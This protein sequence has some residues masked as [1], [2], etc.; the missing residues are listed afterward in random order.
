MDDSREPTT[1]RRMGLS[2]LAG[3][4]GVG[5]CIA[6]ASHRP[7]ILWRAYL[8]GVVSCWL[9]SMG[10]AGLIAIGNLTGG[11]WAAAARPYY[12]A[13]MKTLPV[14]A[15][16]LVPL[17]FALAQIYPWTQANSTGGESFSAAKA[18]YLS[19]PFFLARA[20]AYL[21]VWLFVTR[22]LASVSR[23]E[24]LPGSTL[25]MRR[26]GAL[27][28]VLLVPTVTFAAFD[29]VM[30]LEPHWY[31]SIFGAV[32]TAGG[33]VAAHALAVYGLART[34]ARL[35]RAIVDAA[36]EE[37][38]EGDEKQVAGLFGDLGNLLLAFIMVWTYFSFSQFLIIWSGNLPSEIAWYER[39]LDGGWQFAALGVVALCFVMPFFILLSRDVKQNIW[40]LAVVAMIVLVGYGL[41][42]YWTV[43]PAFQPVNTEEL[44]A[45]AGAM[46]TL[47][48]LWSAL[49]AWQLGRLLRT[50]FGG[51]IDRSR[52][53]ERC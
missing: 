38:V 41:N 6:L 26:A 32:L 18:D 43:V 20:A 44:L 42:M 33:V 13:S 51:A 8:L 23:L 27:S 9:V 17:A 3:A 2:L 40:P 34:P 52:G 46:L 37:V 7:A 11:K 45:S 4:L 50:H 53:Q 10:A 1:Y 30:S 5:I 35:R 39:R 29:W 22:W 14:V 36:A 19:P 48:G 28:L 15:A 24:L 21:I 47:G 31:S 12:L 16:L 25:E 49:N